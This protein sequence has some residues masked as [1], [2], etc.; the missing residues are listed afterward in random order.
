MPAHPHLPIET[1][2]ICW[3]G[4]CVALACAAARADAVSVHLTTSASVDCS[5][6]QSIVRDTCEGRT[7]DEERAVA[8]YDFVRELVFHYPNRPIKRDVHDSLH[9]LNTYG[10]A[11]CSQQA[12]LL[13]DLWHAA[14]IEGEVWEVPGHSTAQAEYGGKHHWFDPLIG[15]YV[16]AR[17][18]GGVASLRDIADDP[19]LLTRSARDGLLPCGA[20]LRDDAA[21]FCKHNAPYIKEC[22][23]LVDDATFMATLASKAKPWAWGDPPKSKYRPDITLRPGEEIEYLWDSIPRQS[24]CNVVAEGGEPREYWVSSDQLPP[25][26]ICGDDAEARDSE[27]EAWQPYVTD[28]QGVRTGRYAANG[29]H[30]YTQDVDDAPVAEIDMRAPHVY[31]GGRVTLDLRAGDGASLYALDLDTGESTEGID[32]I[33]T[34]DGQAQQVS[35]RLDEAIRGIRNLRFVVEGTGV[36]RVAVVDHRVH[37]A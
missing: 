15:A 28:I 5:T 22:A 3:I 17:D 7:T 14:G 6:L 27:F 11:L 18:G 19:T 26:H 24:F 29:T 12:L 30:R 33:W 37:V 10:Y 1:V 16:M 35:I 23:D 36:R 25:H 9:L 20:V 21:A 4:L 32:P 2:S 13:V 34:G 8:L 31:T